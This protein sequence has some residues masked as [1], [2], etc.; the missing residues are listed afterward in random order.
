MICLTS[1]LICIVICFYSVMLC[2]VYSRCAALRYAM[3]LPC[4][5]AVLRILCTPALHWTESVPFVVCCLSLPCACAF[6]YCQSVHRASSSGSPVPLRVHRL[7]T[8][9]F[10]QRAQRC[11]LSH[12]HI[13]DRHNVMLSHRHVVTSSHRHGC[14]AIIV[15]LEVSRNVTSI[16]LSC[17]PYSVSD[18]DCMRIAFCYLLSVIFYICYL[19]G[20]LDFLFIYL[21]IYLICTYAVS[22]IVMRVS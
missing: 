7:T 9:P 13:V 20:L 19:L 17:L 10:M 2:Q 1:V 18:C 21:S 6:V 8:S 12:C 15:R 4:I 14:L 22:K 11:R 16:R 5:I 3:L